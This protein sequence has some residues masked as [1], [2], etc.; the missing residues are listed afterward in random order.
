MTTLV[1]ARVSCMLK[2]TLSSSAFTP[3]A[4]LCGPATVNRRVV[5]QETKR[6][7]NEDISKLEQELESAR[8]RG[9]A[10]IIS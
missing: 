7:S 10:C 8:S 3:P 9:C 4:P 2:R 1:R 6:K 5:V